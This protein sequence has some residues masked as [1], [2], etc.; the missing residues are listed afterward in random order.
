MRTGPYTRVVHPLFCLYVPEEPSIERAAAWNLGRGPKIVTDMKGN[1]CATRE[2]AP[3]RSLLL[4]SGKKHRG[5]NGEAFAQF[6]D[7]GLVEVAFLVQD[8]RYDAFRSEDGDQVLLTEVMGFHQGSKDVPGGKRREWNDALLRKLQLTSSGLPH[9]S[10]LHAWGDL[11]RPA[12]PETDRYSWCWL[13]D[14]IGMG[15]LTGSA[16][17]SD[18]AIMI[19][20][21]PSRRIQRGSKC[22]GYRPF[23]TCEV[24]VKREIGVGASF[25]RHLNSQRPL[26]PTPNPELLTPALLG[27]REHLSARGRN[28]RLGTQT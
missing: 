24:R 13:W 18:T 6:L 20:A 25:P 22:V 19:V 27:C 4:C 14:V 21:N 10:L 12:H 15:A 2:I 28:P 7:A 5:R 23:S 11:C 3:R 16:Y 26:P 17:F 1:V 8:F 9:I